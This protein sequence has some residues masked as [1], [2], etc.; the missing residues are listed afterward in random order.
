[1]SSRETPRETERSEWHRPALD[2]LASDVR[3]VR[4]EMLTGL[5][6]REALDRYFEEDAE[7]MRA[8]GDDQFEEVH[9]ERRVLES[10]KVFSHQER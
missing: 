3:E 1:M 7:R 6:S 10:R 5:E 4:R 9:A 8:K 2:T